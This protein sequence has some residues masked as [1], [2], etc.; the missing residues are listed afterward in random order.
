[1]TRA[2]AGG[3]LLCVAAAT[4]SRPSRA[5]TPPEAEPAA[6]APPFVR[7][8][9]GVDVEFDAD[10]P[11]ISVFVAPGI[12]EDTEPRF[13]DPFV[14]LGR[15]PL[16]VKLVP[17][18]YTV[19]VESPDIATRSTVFQV[20]SQPVHV[21]VRSGS[22]GARGLGTLLLAVGAAS[23]LAA[24]AIEVSYTETPSGIS[25]SKIAIPLFIV[26]GV[27]LAGGLTIYLSSSTTIEQDG[28]KPD[29][30]GG[31]IGVTSRW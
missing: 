8:D 22:A 4:W 21:R 11:H 28:I 26:G 29:R 6:P 25:K 14:K 16:S 1:M 7:A 31:F 10:R 23:A 12:V 5:Q 3:A 24:L 13:P 15:T 19:T 9:T 18:V 27:G 2:A 30:R 17:G 20:G